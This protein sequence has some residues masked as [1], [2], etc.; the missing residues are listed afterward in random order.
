VTA[1]QL[2]LGISE[3]L[4]KDLR[5]FAEAYGITIAAAARVL[6]RMALK[7]EQDAGVD[8]SDR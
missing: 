7:A 6:L 8:R 2:H 4:E 3:D 1:Y 5:A